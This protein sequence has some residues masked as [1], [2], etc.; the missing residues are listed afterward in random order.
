MVCQ[1]TQFLNSGVL[2][3][4]GVS[5]VR[6]WAVSPTN[7]LLFVFSLQFGLGV[8]LN[9]QIVPVYRWLLRVNHPCCCF[10]PGL[11]CKICS[12]FTKAYDAK[13][14]QHAGGSACG[15]MYFSPPTWYR[16]IRVQLWFSP[17]VSSKLIS[18]SEKSWE[19][20]LD[21]SRDFPVYASTSTSMDR[22]PGIVLSAGMRGG[23]KAWRHRC[24][25]VGNGL[26]QWKQ[27]WATRTSI[28]IIR[29]WVSQFNSVPL[30]VHR[31][32]NH[33]D[34]FIMR[35]NEQNGF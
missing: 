6:R 20:L 28:R 5:I 13:T 7:S 16:E 12:F 24:L 31:L 25:A 34:S 17:E 32:V 4:A 30:Q 35:F 21:L 15:N 8:V 27:L 3:L 33:I 14:G 19:W 10:I 23:I 26:Q 18:V 1:S 9:S 22:V 29:L 2:A 11:S